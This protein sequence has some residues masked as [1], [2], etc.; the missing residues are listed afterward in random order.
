MF[1]MLTILVKQCINEP[2]KYL[3]SI[4]KKWNNIL[5]AINRDYCLPSTA[6][7]LRVLVSGWRLMKTFVCVLALMSCKKEPCRPIKRPTITWGSTNSKMEGTWSPATE[8]P[9]AGVRDGGVTTSLHP[10]PLS[11]EPCII[12]WTLRWH[13][14]TDMLVYSLTTAGRQMSL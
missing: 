1:W 3:K 9:P 5:K 10:L 6:Q 4:S 8:L 11:L 12:T 14:T 2:F 7:I 13:L